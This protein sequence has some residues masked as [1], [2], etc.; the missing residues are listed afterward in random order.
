MLR[1]PARVLLLCAG[2][3][4]W[5]RALELFLQGLTAP[6][7]VC[8]AITAA[9]YKKYALVSLIHAGGWGH[10]QAGQLCLSASHTQHIAACVLS[11]VVCNEESV[12]ALPVCW[13]RWQ[14]PSGL[15]A[16]T[17]RCGTRGMFG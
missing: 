17:K 3:K 16:E 8:S 6:T 7:M 1:P 10:T 9:T 4:Q 13:Q 2:R 11:V 12:H 14:N 5:A 15:V